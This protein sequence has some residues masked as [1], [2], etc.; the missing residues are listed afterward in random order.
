MKNK[1]S[2]K[3]YQLYC[4]ICN[5]KKITDGGDMNALVEIKT[6]PI[7]RGIPKK[8]LETG[9]MEKQKYLRQ[10][11]KFRCPNCGRAITPRKLSS[12]N[13]MHTEEMPQN[14]IE[15]QEDILKRIIQ[16]LDQVYGYEE[17]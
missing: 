9:E 7:P 5:W 14:T 8:N 10:P 17:E 11:K 12:L 4:E 1:S 13:P 15:K 2:I 3:R 6:S 16:Q